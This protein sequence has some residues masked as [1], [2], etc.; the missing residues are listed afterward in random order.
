ME[1]VPLLV[2]ECRDCNTK[3]ERLKLKREKVGRVPDC[4]VCGKKMKK[5][6]FPGHAVQFLGDGWSK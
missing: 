4:H 5:V 1:L 2:Y 3:V 6:K